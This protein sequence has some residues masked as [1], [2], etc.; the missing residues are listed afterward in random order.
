A[1]RGAAVLPDER[2]MQRLTGRWVPDA[3]GLALVGDPDR[4]QLAR[5]RV[6][7]RLAGHRLR[8][9]PDLRRVVLDPPR[10]REVLLA[11]PVGVPGE[12]PVL[13][14]D[15]A[16]RPGGALVDGEDHAGGS[17]DGGA[18]ETGRAVPPGPP[19]DFPPPATVGH[20]IAGCL[21]EAFASGGE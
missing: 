6:V 15:E 3:D 8:D 11:L 19:R 9:L 16:R 14:E 21:L 20:P 4:M 2:A 10:L 18:R 17:L 5:A 12:L 1:R 7:E 13:V